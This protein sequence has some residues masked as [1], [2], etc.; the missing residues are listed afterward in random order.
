MGVQ[1]LLAL[2][3]HSQAA[4]LCTHFRHKAAVTVTVNRDSDSVTHLIVPH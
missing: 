3:V 2:T 4:T 1:A